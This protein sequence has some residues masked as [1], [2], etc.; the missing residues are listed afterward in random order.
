MGCWV[1]T[2]WEIMPTWLAICFRCILSVCDFGYFPFWFW[3][4]D[5][6]SDCSSSCSLL[7]HYFWQSR[8]LHL[9]FLLCI[10]YKKLKANGTRK[11]VSVSTPTHWWT[12][13]KGLFIIKG[14]Q[15]AVHCV[16]IDVDT[17]EKFSHSH[18][19]QISS[20]GVW[21]S[22]DLHLSSNTLY[23]LSPHLCF[24]HLESGQVWSC[25]W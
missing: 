2:F 7:S 14:H 6:P 21:Q 10:L 9:F 1:T 8:D 24:L 18:L 13:K 5:L 22:R 17:D 25:H 4:Q 11:F 12:A 16:L 20:G 19:L 23:M 15:W 3:W